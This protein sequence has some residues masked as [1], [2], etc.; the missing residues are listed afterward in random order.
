MRFLFTLI[1]I[2]F[3]A[4][5]LI[6]FGVQWTHGSGDDDSDPV[7][8]ISDVLDEEMIDT[9][10]QW[11]Y[12]KIEYLHDIL[13]PDLYFMLLRG[14]PGSPIPMIEGGYATTDVWVTVR[15]HGVE[16]ARPLQEKSVRHRPHNY[17]DN[18]RRRWDRAMAYVWS[19]CGPNGTFR[20]G[21]LE[22]IE[23]DKVLK[24]DIE[25]LLG[26]QWHLLSVAML[27]DFHALAEGGDWDFGA[28]E[29]GVAN[30]NIPK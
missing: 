13:R 28:P 24:G 3:L 9:E 29:F 14:H 30:P 21:N 26:G 8:E 17:L 18:E 1:G 27:N 10:P 20:V 5:L 16:V 15:L 4:M 12:G 25:F 23:A 7:E 2:I 19:V 6:Y 11:V 22:V